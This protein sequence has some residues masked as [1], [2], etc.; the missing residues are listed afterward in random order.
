MAARYLNRK[1]LP[2]QSRALI[3]FFTQR[4]SADPLLG[5]S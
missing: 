5:Q 3:D 2:P 1:F 4:C